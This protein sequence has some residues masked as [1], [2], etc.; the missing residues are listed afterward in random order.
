[1][2]ASDDHPADWK[3]T[4]LVSAALES[5]LLAA[6]A[7]PCAA[8]EAARSA[9]LDP[10][11]AA[12]AARALVDAGCLEDAGAGRLRLAGW[13]ATL[14]RSDEGEGL[15]GTL[16]LEARAIRSHL[17]LAQTLR[18]G[19][20]Q[21][22]VS[23]GDRVTR[24]RFMHAMRRVAAPR[25][26]ATV[27]ALGTPAPGAPLLDVGGA[28][29]TYA[30]GF[31]AAGWDVTVLDLPDTLEI[32]APDLHASGVRTVAGDATREIPDGPWDVVYIGNVLHLLGPDEA[33]ALVARAARALA[34][35]G[36][37]AIQ[38]VLGDLSPQG[39]GFGVMMLLS[40]EAGDAHPRAAYAAWMEAAGRPLQ[41]VV[42]LEEGWHHLMLGG[43][44]A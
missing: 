44:A 29:G 18:T 3:W 8:P 25:A 28:P 9:R 20:P 10:R 42:S 23:G 4:L 5:G 19:R 40:T 16:A 37:L 38:E 22:D 7:V 13:G 15:A 32:G 35:S 34:P 11:A 26:P 21:D 33:A 17:A 6:F 14:V 12:I 30:L 31:A 1:M 39:R 36:R 41:R 27:E 24:E 43:P 2:A